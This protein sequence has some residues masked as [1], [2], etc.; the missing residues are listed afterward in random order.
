[1]AN[2][3]VGLGEAIGQALS[4][5]VCLPIGLMIG[6]AKVMLCCEAEPARCPK[7]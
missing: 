1:M 4:Q 7:E 5:M 3:T 2:L 6:R